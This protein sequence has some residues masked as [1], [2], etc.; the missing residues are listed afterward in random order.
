MNKFF[1]TAALL[2]AALFTF[3]AC[4]DDDEKVI[5][6][7]VDAVKPVKVKAEFSF[8]PKDYIEFYDIT[9]TYTDPA[10]GLKTITLGGNTTK[11]NCEA[12][13]TYGNAPAQFI[14]KVVGKLKSNYKDLVDKDKTYEFGY[15]RSGLVAAFNKEGKIVRTYGSLENMTSSS[16]V[17]GDKLLEAIEK[18]GYFK[19]ERIFIDAD[20]KINQ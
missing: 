13:Y 2:C 16:T 12:E 4:D 1:L 11:W 3:T 15:N 8:E 7:I 5:D 10:A 19:E 17:K 9:V 6:E 18:N 20:V 14:C